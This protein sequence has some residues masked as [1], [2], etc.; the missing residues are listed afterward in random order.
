MDTIR[1]YVAYNRWANTKI[2]G[3]LKGI[4]EDDFNKN[5]GNSF[6]SIRDT[7]LHIYGAEKIWLG[8][9]EG[10]PQTPFPHF[11]PL[12]YKEDCLSFWQDSSKAFE[13]FIASR[14]DAFFLKGIRYGRQEK[15]EETVAW[16]ITQHCIN[17]SSFH[18]GQ[19]ITMLR[20]LG[21]DTIPM[22]DFIKYQR[23]VSP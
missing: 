11:D 14:D 12:P 13:D 6:P 8:R 16:W 7:I 15:E 9:L 19:I 17:H 3:F 10:K 1:Q 18:R 4:N 20:Q 21:Y 2:I 23:V 22:T 5:M